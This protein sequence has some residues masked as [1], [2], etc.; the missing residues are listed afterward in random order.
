MQTMVATTRSASRS[1]S[2]ATSPTRPLSPSVKKTAKNFAVTEPRWPVR[3]FILGALFLAVE[4]ALKYLAYKYPPSQRLLTVGEFVYF[5]LCSV[6]NPHSALSMLRN[7]PV[8]ARNV[9]M[10]LSVSLLIFITYQQVV[11]PKSTV[12]TRRGI[13]CL[14]IGAIGN[15]PDRLLVGGVVDYIYF[16]TGAWGNHYSLAWNIS[17]L[18]INCGLG[19]VLLS[20]IREEREEKK[21]SE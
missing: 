19:H 17:D 7:V 20:A 3:W 8:W 13:F 2:T 4:F 18:L 15:G 11:S 16:Q 10:L 1:K 14:I 6:V 9:L 5:E 21:K 12:L